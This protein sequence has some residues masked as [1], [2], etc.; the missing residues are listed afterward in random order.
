MFSGVF[1]SGRNIAL[2][3][4]DLVNSADIAYPRHYFSPCLFT[5]SLSMNT[6]NVK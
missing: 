1:A 5:R 3:D 4:G 6:M 2:Q